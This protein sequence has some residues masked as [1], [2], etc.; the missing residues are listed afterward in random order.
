MKSFRCS[1]K[2]G[3]YETHV[4]K[5]MKRR[6]INT[7]EKVIKDKDDDDVLTVVEEEESSGQDGMEEP[8]DDGEDTQEDGAALQG[9][10]CRT[11]VR[12]ALST[13]GLSITSSFS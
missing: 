7:M 10:A 13:S 2:S 5:T 12:S 8:G 6:E 3:S 4:T 1:K 11:A 9:A